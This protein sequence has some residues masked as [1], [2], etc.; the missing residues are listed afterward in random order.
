LYLVSA[1]LLG[2]AFGQSFPLFSV[3]VC[4][5]SYH[6][7]AACI[8]WSTR[9][10]IVQWIGSMVIFLPFFGLLKNRIA[11]PLQ[12]EFSLLENALM[13][14]VGVVSFGL[15][16]VGVARQRRGDARASV[17][18]T[19]SSAGTPD[20]LISLFKI[21]CPTSSATRAQVWFE[22]KT[23]GL[24]VLTIGL[25]VA[26]LI[27]LL[28]AISVAV[29]PVRPFAFGAA[30][31]SVPALL[32]VLGGNAFGIR[33]RQGRTYASSFEATQPYGTAQLASLKVLVRSG[34]LLAALIA[35]G[36][37]AWTSS[38]LMDAW[39][40]WADGR[41]EVI[42][43]LLKLRSQIGDAFGGLTGYALAAQAVVASIAVAV[44]VAGRAALEALRARYPRRLLVV[45]SLLLLWCLTIILMVLAGR[46]R[47]A[48]EFLVDA[49]IW[50]KR[51]VTAGTLVPAA[52]IVL[53]TVYLFW[54]GLAERVLTL[55]YACGAL[56]ISAA[57][58][59]AW[60][61]VLQTAGVQLAT[62]P[63]ANAVP[64]LSLLL[65]PLMA[66]AL[67][68]WSLSRTRHI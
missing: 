43:G 42:L 44:M 57:F 14:L 61:T 8:Q 5:V 46:S 65:L 59:A 2:F 7:A 21:P 3:A 22:L 11:S 13:I 62:L 36:V 49:I 15:T 23:S 26:L 17:P 52:V 29:V 67:A 28:F 66:S 25:A 38:S 24:P 54:S 37:S 63:A 64:I 9:N 33:R 47:I 34:C 30:V 55:R 32:F 45:G 18:R 50:A 1:A 68:P 6:L 4:L 16:V 10:R 31:F 12:V 53:A 41:R 48:S 60:L 35:V 27:A 20:W 58:G 40:T 39:G 56:V 51:W 19:K